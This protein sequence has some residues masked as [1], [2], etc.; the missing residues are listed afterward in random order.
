LQY[1]QQYGF[2]TFDT[3]WDESY[4]RV[5]DDTKRSYYLSHLLKKLDQQS[6]QE[7]NEMFKKSIPIIE[8]NWNHFYGGGFEKI[9]WAELTTMFDNLKAATQGDLSSN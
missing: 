1:L 7:K 8:H 9:L 3:I 4:D 5:Q 2:K 6:E